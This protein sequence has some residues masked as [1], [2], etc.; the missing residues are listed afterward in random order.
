MDKLLTALSH[1]HVRIQSAKDGCGTRAIV[2]SHEVTDASPFSTAVSIWSRRA[3]APPTTT[4]PPRA[5]LPRGEIGPCRWH[6]GQKPLGRGT[7]VLP[8]RERRSRITHMSRVGALLPDRQNRRLDHRVRGS[9]V[10]P[11]R[12]IKCGRIHCVASASRFLGCEYPLQRASR[13][14]VT[15]WFR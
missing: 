8:Y 9:R 13:S 3:R 14:P 11:V 6:C 1:Y 2:G 12:I 5:R 10:A 4:W 7:S 15:T